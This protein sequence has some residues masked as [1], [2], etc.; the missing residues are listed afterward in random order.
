MQGVADIASRMCLWV[1]V[2]TYVPC[3]Y[4]SQ[5]DQGRPTS[6]LASPMD[7]KTPKTSAFLNLILGQI[8]FS[9]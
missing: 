9:T 2:G 6:S 7:S 3:E 5:F 1:K 4:P 8:L